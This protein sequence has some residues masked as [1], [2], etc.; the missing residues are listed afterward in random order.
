MVIDI[1]NEQIDKILHL[2]KLVEKEA[3]EN[4]K[5]MLICQL[6]YKQ[7]QLDVRFLYHDDAKMISKLIQTMFLE[8]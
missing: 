3:L 4:K 6:D 2:I 5:G 1:T 8:K 7:K